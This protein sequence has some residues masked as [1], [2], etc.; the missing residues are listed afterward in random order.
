MTAERRVVDALVIG[1]GLA[2]LWAV[3]H[4]PQDWRIAV[5]D[6]GPGED[7]GSS[8]WAQGGMA[9]AIGADDSPAR[10]SADTLRAGAGACSRAAVEVLTSEGPAALDGLVEA[11]CRFDRTADGSF[12]LH[13]EGGQSVARS[14]HVADAT[15][16]EL[17]RAVLER[18]RTRAERIRG[19]AVRLEVARGR[20]VGATV[21][22]PDGPTT[23]L[24]RSIVLATGGCG[25]L[26][27]AT[28]NP[29]VATGD[30]AALAY[31]AGAAVADLEFVQFHPTAL[32]TEGHRRVLLTEAL[33]GDGAHIVDGDGHRFLLDIHPDGEL[34]PRDVVA[35][36]IAERG[37][38]FLDAGPIGTGRLKERFPN[39]YAAALEAGFDLAAGPV[40]VAPA[41]HYFLGGVATDLHGRTTLDGLYAVG[42][43]AASGVH[44][45]NRMAGNSLTEAVVF[46]RRAASAAVRDAHDPPPADLD[47]PALPGAGVGA[48]GDGWSRLRRAMSTGVGL[49]R[50]GQSVTEAEAVV[51]E[52]AEATPDASLRLAAVT[53]GLICRAAGLRTESRGTHLRADYPVPRPQWEG[54]RLVFRAPA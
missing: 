23:V 47:L 32:A 14:V 9:V 19:S 2:G 22:M 35:R 39:V 26:Y 24:A 7:T 10:H 36:A 37:G 17:M 52:I 30:A 5:V 46:G 4:L 20:C 18:A 49:A 41:A 45:A 12:D 25:A 34:G 50:T 13:R 6:K 1:G 48:A 44:G 43:C 16:R 21:A 31:E 27:E 51:A 54:V 38:A 3:L 8:P 11:G 15:G 33:R 29:P 42:E 53:A 40:P 28:T